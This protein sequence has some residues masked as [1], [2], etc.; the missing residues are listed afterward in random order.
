VTTANQQKAIIE[1]GTQIPYLEASSSGAATIS[2]KE[3]TLSLAVTPQI[4]PDNKIIMDLEVKKDRVGQIF[5]GVPSIDTQRVQ[6]QVLV[7]NGE[8][9]VLGG[10]YEQTERN[11]VDK[12]P[13]F[14]DLPF[15]GNVFKRTT[16][17]NE[18]T[19]LLIFITPKV[20][21]ED[22]NLR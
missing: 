5:A 18:K 21:D 19:E 1:Q 10:I 9:A 15:I 11:D 8:T 14:G 3:A 12:V 2:F 20:L 22:L 17:S 13:F 4:T 16:K 6:T 7:S